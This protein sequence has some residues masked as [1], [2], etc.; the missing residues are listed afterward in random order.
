MQM[1]FNTMRLVL[2]T[3]MTAFFVFPLFAQVD[4]LVQDTP[5]LFG[6]WYS[7]SDWGD[8]DNDMDLDLIMNGYGAGGASGD[9][10]HKFYRNDGNSTF[11]LL[12]TGILGTGNGSVRFADF[13]G[14]NDLDA[15]VC[16]QYVMSVDTTRVYINNAGVFTDC[17]FNFPPR[18]SSSLSIGDFDCDGDADILM[19]GGTIDDISNGFVEIYRNDGAFQFTQINVVSPGIRNGNAEFGD[20]DSDSWLDIAYTGS[21]GSGNY[22]AKILHGNSTGIFNEVA[23]LAGLRYSRISWVDTDADGDLDVILS[24]SFV[25]EQPSVFKHYLNEGNNTFTE[26]AQPAVMGE[27]QGDMVWGDINNDG[28][29][30]IIINGLIS[31]TSWVANVYLYYPQTGLFDSTQIMTYLK[32][33][34]MTLGDYNNDNKLDMSL[35]GYYDYQVYWNNLYQNTCAT[36]NTPPSPPAD[37][38]E[39]VNDHDVLLQWGQGADIETPADGLTYNIRVGTTSGG[40][41]IVSSMS[42]TATGWRKVARPGNAWQRSFYPLFGLADGTYYWSVQSID[43]SY[44]GS[45]FAAEQTFNIGVVGNNDSLLPVVTNVSNHPNPFNSATEIKF[46]ANISGKVI[47]GIYN[48]KG[49]L[50]KTLVDADLNAGSHSLAWDGTDDSGKILPSGVYTLRMQNELQTTTHKMMIIK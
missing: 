22:V 19:T 2:L 36:A 14:D 47:A 7:E 50:V 40:N 37:L 33:A 5:Q 12:D 24:G 42:D 13:D 48:V 27:R 28:Y 39:A 49:Q 43:N 17:G 23:S 10:F 46:T 1:E 41:D 21:A 29:A 26:F 15:L 20:Y 16:G 45:A 31:N 3:I 9:G 30:D 11:T 25:N 44:A 32:Y 35:S 34:A 38:S 18:V 8:F 6:L 4:L